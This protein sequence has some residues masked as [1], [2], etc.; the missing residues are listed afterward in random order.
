LLSTW[1]GIGWDVITKSNGLGAALAL[2]YEHLDA[3][4]DNWV[5]HYVDNNGEYLGP[6]EKPLKK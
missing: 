3:T 4:V 5:G 2:G 6:G 1:S